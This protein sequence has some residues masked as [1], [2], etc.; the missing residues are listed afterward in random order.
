MV[1]A[2]DHTVSGVLTQVDENGREFPL[3]FSSQKLT[4]T[5]QG[6]AT[7]EKEAY[8]ALSALRRYRGWVFGA[9]V[10]VYSDHNPLTFLTESAPRSAKLMRWA[11]ALQEFNVEFRYRAGHKNTVPDVLTRLVDN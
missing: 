6:W 3:A 11:L 10:V 2:S 4:K 9:K 5:Q 1:D 7:V 8:A